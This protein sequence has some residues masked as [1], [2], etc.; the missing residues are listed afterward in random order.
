[1][2]YLI[3]PDLLS[4]GRNALMS[5][6]HT[7]FY[8]KQSEC[9]QPLGLHF[10][11]VWHMVMGISKMHHCEDIGDEKGCL[12]LMNVGLCHSEHSPLTQTA[13]WNFCSCCLYCKANYIPESH[14]FLSIVN[15]FKFSLCSYFHLSQLLNILLF[16]PYYCPRQT[17]LSPGGTQVC[18]CESWVLLSWCRFHPNSNI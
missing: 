5:K 17:L 7:V 14:T 16:L 3:I 10:C 15:V 13:F 9:S 4:Q 11:C 12:G 2:L 1:M 6:T 18:R 8:P